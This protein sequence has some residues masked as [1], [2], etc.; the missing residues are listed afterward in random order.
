MFFLKKMFLFF[1]ISALHFKK[2]KK[3]AKWILSCLFTA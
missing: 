2:I 1:K 3:N